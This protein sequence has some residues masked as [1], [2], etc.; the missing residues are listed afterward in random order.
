[1]KQTRMKLKCAPRFCTER[2]VLVIYVQNLINTI[3]QCSL[4]DVLSLKP[5]KSF[6]IELQNG[7][8]CGAINSD[9][10]SVVNAY[11]ICL[12]SCSSSCR[13]ALLSLRTRHG[14]CLTDN[15][16]LLT[17]SFKLSFTTCAISLPGSWKKKNLNV[18]SSV[19]TGA[20][21]GRNTTELLRTNFP[22]CMHAPEHSA[23]PVLASYPGSL[24]PGEENRAWYLTFARASILH[25]FGVTRNL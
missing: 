2:N 3:G 17:L 15:P 23:Y 1:M 7:E 19:N 5:Q 6:A 22:F 12:S 24:Y 9:T 18:P 4:K 11:F 25:T 16:L 8:Y 14:C 20:S 21:C 13:S 10:A